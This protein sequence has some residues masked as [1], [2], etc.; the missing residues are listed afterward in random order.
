MEDEGAEEIDDN[1]YSSE[2]DDGSNS[3]SSGEE[4]EMDGEHA[5]NANGETSL[6]EKMEAERK[7]KI[8]PI[9][10]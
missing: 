8:I 1:N 6:L 7:R 9:K 2:I 3:E 10:I 4:E 5:A